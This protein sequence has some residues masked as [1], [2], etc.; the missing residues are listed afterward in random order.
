MS[1]SRSRPP[2]PGS[3]ATESN[4]ARLSVDSPDNSARPA[5]VESWSSG[6]TRPSSSSLRPSSDRL[7]VSAGHHF[8]IIGKSQSGKT[9]LAKLCLRQVQSYVVVYTKGAGEWGPADGIVTADPEAIL[10]HPRVIWTPPLFA[11]RR[12]DPLGRDVYSRGLRYIFEHRGDPS[13]R[14]AVTVVFDE[15]KWQIPTEPNPYA[16]LL[17]H[18]GMGKGIGVW[19]LS[20]GV[21]GIFTPCVADAKVVAC[22]RL[23]SK[24]ARTQLA[25]DL[26][27]ESADPLGGLEDH[28]FMVHL[29]GQDTF[30]GPMKLPP[31]LATELSHRPV[32]TDDAVDMS[33]SAP[34]AR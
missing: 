19:T 21:Y 27:V 14:P 24:R 31:R 30:Q 7:E 16:M 10:Y 9:V 34:P 1:S 29:E 5:S 17:V 12:P 28:A 11:V 26:E 33:R 15:G 3:P 18:Q 32:A 4:D 23:A 6:R 20:Q 13:G 25:G 22:F 2:T 8:T